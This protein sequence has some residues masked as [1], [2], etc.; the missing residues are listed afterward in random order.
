MD[1]AESHVILRQC[2]DVRRV[3]EARRALDENLGELEVRE[4]RRVFVVHV[5]E[6]LQ[7]WPAVCQ[8]LLNEVMVGS[9]IF[10]VG[11]R[12]NRSRNQYLFRNTFLGQITSTKP[13]LPSTRALSG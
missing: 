9:G 6:N 2:V 3:Q 8:A 12:L 11:I 13:Q 1:E 10:P 4:D 5:F 7:S